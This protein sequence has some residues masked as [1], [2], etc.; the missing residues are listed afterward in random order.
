M[1][2]SK[3]IEALEHIR[4]ISRVKT[5]SLQKIDNA[6][7]DNIALE[8]VLRLTT[9]DYEWQCQ[10]FEA[11]QGKLEFKE[12]LS[13]YSNRVSF[14]MHFLSG[15]DITLDDDHCNA[16]GEWVIWQPFTIEETA[17]IL[18]GR[19]VDTFTLDSQQ[20]KISRTQLIVEILTPWTDTW[21]EELVSSKWR[22]P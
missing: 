1:E 9:E 19:S 12:F 6:I 2:L 4:S 16:R 14:S 7:N 13:R 11:V 3:R 15:Y 17:W 22:W 8:E 20:W 10:Q 21:G 5:I 18:A